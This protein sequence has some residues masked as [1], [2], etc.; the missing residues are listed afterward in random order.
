MI[1]MGGDGGLPGHFASQ[2]VEGAA[3][4]CA[5]TRP[6]AKTFFARG[7]LHSENSIMRYEALTVTGGKIVSKSRRKINQLIIVIYQVLYII[8]THILE[9]LYLLSI[10]LRISFV[11]GK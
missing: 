5:E 4:L 6:M 7:A 8:T 11:R 9:L 1:S 10:K 3:S 2:H